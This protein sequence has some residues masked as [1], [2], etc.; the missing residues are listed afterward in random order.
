[1][2]STLYAAR[3]PW[4]SRKPTKP[5]IVATI[6]ERSRGS[7]AGAGPSREAETGSVGAGAADSDLAA[8][9]ERDFMV[10]FSA[11]AERPCNQ[12]LALT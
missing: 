7:T 11:S 10:L 9:L 12:A 8:A 4:I 2:T 5:I 3:I 1:M 6:A